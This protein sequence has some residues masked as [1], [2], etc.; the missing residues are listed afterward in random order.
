M[1]KWRSLAGTYPEW[2]RVVGIVD[3]TPFR[4]SKPK[5][6][7][8]EHVVYFLFV[9]RIYYKLFNAYDCIKHCILEKKI[10]CRCNTKNILPKG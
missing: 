6:E 4:I 8:Y 3:C 2:P 10:L 9:V 1:N 5:G 7:Y